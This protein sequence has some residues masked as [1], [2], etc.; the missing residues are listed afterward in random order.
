[1]HLP[2]R[3]F[4]VAT[5]FVLLVASDLLPVGSALESSLDLSASVHNPSPQT[6]SIKSGAAFDPLAIF[7]SNQVL[8]EESCMSPGITRVEL[9][10]STGQTCIEFSNLGFN[11]MPELYWGYPIKKDAQ[12]RTSV[13]NLLAQYFRNFA[14]PSQQDLYEEK[15]TSNLEYA[16]FVGALVRMDKRDFPG[17]A[18]Q[19]TNTHSLRAALTPWAEQIAKH[20]N[21][22]TEFFVTIKDGI[23]IS[24]AKSGEVTQERLDALIAKSDVIAAYALKVDAAYQLNSFFPSDTKTAERFLFIDSLVD[25]SEAAAKQAYLDMAIRNAIRIHPD[26]QTEIESGLSV[27]QILKAKNAKAAAASLKMVKPK[28]PVVTR[29]K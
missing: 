20:Y 26:I 29:K 6:M 19:V 23:L 12:L 11:K 14:S 22:P 18:D 25:K 4:V 27:V 3:W 17:F 5:A 24:L 10:S 7:A 9:R 16:A 21:L 13:D 2:Q 1:M 28:A 15:I 8:D